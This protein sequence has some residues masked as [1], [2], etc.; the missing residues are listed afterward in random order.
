MI[1]RII[2]KTKAIVQC[3]ICGHEYENTL[4]LI[5]RNNPKSCPRCRFKG[6]KR[7]PLTEDHKLKLINS[8]RGKPSWIKGKTHTAETRKKLS[9]SHKNQVSWC[10]GKKFTLQHRKNCSLSH[11]GKKLSEE[12]KQ[13][14]R[15]ININI[16]KER[17][18]ASNISFPNR[19]IKEINVI[20]NY[21]QPNCSYKI[22]LDKVVCGYILDGYIEELNLVIEFD[23]TANHSYPRQIDNDILRESRIKKEINC[24]F[25]RIKE[26]EWDADK[27]NIINNFKKKIQK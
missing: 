2:S 17:F 13:K 11:I 7:K 25:F 15:E 14:L 10:K 12:H 22:I 16:L 3:D 1:K 19:G 5:N 4:R 26:I 23:E 27:E 18:K 21:L 20:D 6:I 9:Q 24:E 8:R